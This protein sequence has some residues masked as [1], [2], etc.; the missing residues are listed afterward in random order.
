MSVK[1]NII[2]WDRYFH[3]IGLNPSLADSYMQYV[4]RMLELGVPVIFEFEHL[5]ALL[6]RSTGYLASAVNVTK[7]H[8]RT[9]D[10]PKR[11]GGTRKI[12]APYPALLQC[13]Q[14]INH[15]ILAQVPL[16]EAAHGFRKGRSILTN[17]S[18]HCARKH[19]LKMDLKDFF[20][21]VGIRRVIKVFQFFGYPHNVSVY[22]ARLCCLNDVLPQGAA[23]SPLLSN[24][25]ARRLDARLSGLANKQNIQYS[26]YA[27]D[28]VFSGD[29]IFPWFIEAVAR[30]ARAEGFE[31]NKTKT[32]LIRSD[33]RRIVTGL[34]V[35]GEKPRLPS[36]YKRSVRQE[37]HYIVAYGFESHLSKKK[38]RDPFY[39]DSLYGK[40]TFWKSVEPENEFVRKYL[41]EIEAIKFG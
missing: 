2:E 17:A 18:I 5:A 7:H 39:I 19:L 14:W 30:I 13:Q 28:M 26:R 36:S 16:D 22:L 27:D 29:A 11:S 38:I 34:S 8:Y 3:G 33:R 4:T 1:K 31:V 9:F 23:T 32:Q 35:V 37:V 20:P 21:S 24:I 12:D 25:I 6:G 10:I 41:P 15:N 40:L